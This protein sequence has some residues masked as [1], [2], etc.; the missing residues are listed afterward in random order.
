MVRFPW[1]DENEAEP[2]NGREEPSDPR[3]EA[4]PIVSCTFQDGALFVYEDRLYIDRPGS[5]K[6]PGKWITLDQVRGVTVD[7]RL[8][9]SYIQIQQLD[10][11]NSESGIATTPVDE[12]TLHFGGGKRDCASRAR[13]AIVERADIQLG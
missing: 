10:F 7:R 6:F 4:D 12:N 11:E 2:G 13:D 5:S 9:V 3:P 8:L 1:S